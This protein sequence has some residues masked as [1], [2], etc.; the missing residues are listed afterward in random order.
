MNDK[1]FYRGSSS[2]KPLMTITGG[3]VVAG[4]YVAYKIFQRE[5]GV[6]I[7]PSPDENP[8]LRTAHSHEYEMRPPLNAAK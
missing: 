6:S 7:Y 5:R 1:G 3:A 2:I 8:Y 4:L